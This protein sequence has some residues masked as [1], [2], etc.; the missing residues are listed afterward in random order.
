M[1]RSGKVKEVWVDLEVWEEQL[2]LY[3]GKARLA[4]ATRSIGIRRRHQAAR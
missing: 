4:I 3:V 1:F 2:S